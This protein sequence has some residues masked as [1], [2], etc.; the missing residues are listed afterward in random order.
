VVTFVVA[1]CIVYAFDVY[2]WL[3]VDSSVQAWSLH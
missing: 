1:I 2:A 3:Y